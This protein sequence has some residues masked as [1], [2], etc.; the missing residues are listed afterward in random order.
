MLAKLGFSVDVASNGHEVLH[1]T[2]QFRY[3]LVLMDCQM[4]DMDGFEAT[5]QLRQREKS[6]EKTVEGQARP[7][8]IIALTA[9]AMQGDRELCLN[10]G[11]NDYLS[12]PIRLPALSAM[13][14][15][16]LA[17]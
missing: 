16:W 1:M 5:S 17:I 7:I 13:L 6:L 3:D 15:R 8:P 14:D 10:A 9:N 2:Q 4:P 11:M 12:K